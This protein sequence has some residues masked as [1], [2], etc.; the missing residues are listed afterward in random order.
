MTSADPRVSICR[1]CQH[2]QPEGRRGGHCHQLT[3]SVQAAWTACSLAV[4][5]FNRLFTTEPV[6]TLPTV[7]IA[8]PVVHERTELMKVTAALEETFLEAAEAVFP[9]QSSSKIIS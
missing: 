3:G 2:Y 1:H 5:V 8:E 4:P 6:T 7:T 9:E